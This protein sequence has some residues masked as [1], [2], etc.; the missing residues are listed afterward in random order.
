MEELDF[1]GFFVD[2]E[3]P[4]AFLGGFSFL[5]V[6]F[7]AA[8]GVLR[9]LLLEGVEDGAATVAKLGCN[10]AAAE[11]AEGAAEEDDEEDD[12]DDEEEKV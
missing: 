7:A 8:A 11:E 9:F 10:P 2:G 3:D 6:A 1:F 4:P 5:T 12:E